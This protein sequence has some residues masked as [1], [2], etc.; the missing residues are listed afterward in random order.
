[1][2][3]RRCGTV[4]PADSAVTFVRHQ[5]LRSGDFRSFADD[6]HRNQRSCSFV[7][8]FR[9]YFLNGGRLDRQNRRLHLPRDVPTVGKVYRAPSW[10][11]PGGSDTPRNGIAIAWS[12]RD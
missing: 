8:A 12:R 3:V 10:M 7:D 4:R 2:R 6:L 5:T 11:L 1:M 9:S